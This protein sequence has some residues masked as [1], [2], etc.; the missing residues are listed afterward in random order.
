MTIPAPGDVVHAQAPGKVNVYLDVGAQQADGYHDVASVYMAVSVV[1]DVWAAHDDRFRVSVAGDVPTTAVPGDERNLAVRAARLLAEEIGWRG[2]AHLRIRKSVPVAGGMGGGSADAAAALVACDAL[3]N[4]GLAPADL[5]A[6]AARLGADVPFA[7]R[8]GTAVG[9]GRGDD[10]SPAPA[11][12]RFDWV[13]ITAAAGLS[14][15]EV[16]A[17]LDSI[18]RHTGDAAGPRVPRVD[19]AV[20]SALRAGDPE[21]LGRALRNDLQAGAIALRP[22]LAEVLAA[23]TDAGAVAGTVSGSGPTV[24]LL[25][26]DAPAAERV[27]AAMTAAGYRALAAHGPVPGARV[28]G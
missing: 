23:G 7:L 22:Q 2:G 24:A 11:R 18:R 15:P 19:P 28:V 12:G 10:L 4:A 27:R 14:T 9:A 25:V 1:E 21:M 3:W 8:G 5:H 20:L 6:L 16:Y 26:S 13:L 17:E